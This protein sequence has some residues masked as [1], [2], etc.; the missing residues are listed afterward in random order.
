MEQFRRLGHTIWAAL[1][2]DACVA[3]LGI[4][5]VDGGA[6]PRLAAYAEVEA[7]CSDAASGDSE[8]FRDM[9]DDV[10]RGDRLPHLVEPPGPRLSY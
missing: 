8:S 5:H 10:R 3:V 1:S 2:V 9:A 7:F 4:P 6:G